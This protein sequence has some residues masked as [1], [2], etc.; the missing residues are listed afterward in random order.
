[1]ARMPRFRSLV[2][3]LALAAC[4][5][6]TAATAPPSS[7]VVTAT[8]APTDAASTAFLEP[9]E[10]AMPSPQPTPSAPFTL[11]SAAFKE[12]GAIPMLYTCDSHDTSPPLAWTRAPAGAA[13]FALLMTDPDAADFVHWVVYN[14]ASDVSQLTFAIPASADGVPQGL[15][16][17][18]RIGYGG[19]CPPSGTH[20]YVFRLLALDASLKLGGTP[21]ASDVLAAAKGHILAEAKLIGTY[22][23]G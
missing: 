16:S 17:F 5:G 8:P 13:S 18:G 6:E 15:N 7:P 20:H 2:V 19:P 21:R 12:G 11:T 10:T 4:T 1:M 22:R 14:L 23:R 9:V 3:C